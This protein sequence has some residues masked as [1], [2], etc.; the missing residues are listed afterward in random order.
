M[1]TTDKDEQNEGF[2]ALTL[3]IDT[4]QA[5][6]DDPE[7]SEDQKREFI[8]T[9]WAIIVQCVDWGYGIHP[10]QQTEAEQ[11]SQHPILAGLFADCAT[12]NDQDGARKTP[13]NNEPQNTPQSEETALEGADL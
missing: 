1:N 4:Y 5:L 11:P 12:E 8:E 6:L 3:D 9:L 7:L 10:V 13:P 2:K